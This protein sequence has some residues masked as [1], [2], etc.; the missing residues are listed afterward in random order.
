MSELTDALVYL[1]LLFS[2]SHN[3]L[4]NFLKKMLISRC[5][6]WLSASKSL[7][8]YSVYLQCCLVPPSCWSPIVLF[9]NWTDIPISAKNQ[10]N[11]NKLSLSFS[12]KLLAAAGSLRTRKSAVYILCFQSLRTIVTSQ[13][14]WQPSMCDSMQSP[15]KSQTIDSSSVMPGPTAQA[16]FRNKLE[17]HK[18]RTRESGCQSEQSVFSQPFCDLD[19]PS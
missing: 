3:T 14:S 18:L 6:P 13:P 11:A 8:P 1:C 5:S 9:P 16:L 7:L 19:T 4:W 12:P 10:S 2:V 15:S 17:E